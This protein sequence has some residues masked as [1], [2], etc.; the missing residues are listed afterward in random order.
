M[1]QT[2]TTT[3]S[4][5]L[6]KE[7]Q[8]KGPRA[9]R[10]FLRQ[11]GLIQQILQTASAPQSGFGPESFPAHIFYKKN[12]RTPMFI[13]QGLGR[14]Y[15]NLDLDDKL[16]ERL[17]LESKIIEDA[18]GAVDFWWVTANKARSWSLPGAAQI[19]SERHLEACG[20]AWAWIEAQ[21]WTTHRYQEEE[22]E[23]TANYFARKLKKV[24]WP[25]PKKETAILL[26][27]T[28]EELE[29]VHEKISVLDMNH[30]E[31]GIHEARRQIR[32]FS[33]Y[34]SALE[35]SFILNKDARPP[36][37][38]E[39]YLQK[40]IVENPFNKLPPTEPDDRPI[41][42]P[43]HLFYALSY[44]IDRLGVIKDRAQWTDTMKQLVQASGER[45]EKPLSELMAGVY[46]EH[47]EAAKMG[48]EVVKQVLERD[49]LLPRMIEALKDQA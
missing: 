24:D 17:K 13:L 1:S 44:A 25:S 34:A 37:N 23:L 16:F 27:W 40:D 41:E 26:D 49:K 10:R 30:I 33:I 36:E 43:A 3:N 22:H 11:L 12:G 46:L 29:S 31:E 32:W 20:R 45:P 5:T 14:V 47:E 35:G 9:Q 18:V 19:A 48:I 21:H 15:E 7:I 4:S 39:T 6:G 2:E 42:I 8:N 38:W 28:I